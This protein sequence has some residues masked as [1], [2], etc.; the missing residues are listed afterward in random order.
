MK[1]RVLFLLFLS[2][3]FGK[4][5][6]VSLFDTNSTNGIWQ[7]VGVGG[8][9]IISNSSTTSSSDD[10]TAVNNPTIP[11]EDRTDS[12]SS[13]DTV[14]TGVYD[15]HGFSEDEVAISSI[16]DTNLSNDSF[17]KLNDSGTLVMY[18]YNPIAE[19]S[20]LYY[21]SKNS[22]SDNEF[23]TLKKGFGYWA[24]YDDTNL[25]F[26]SNSEKLSN[27]GF[28]F[29]NS[30]EMGIETYTAKIFEGWNL[31]SIPDK[32]T[33]ERGY[34]AT[35]DYD[36]NSE[37]NFSIA[38]KSSLD[39]RN[40]YIDSNS[41]DEA[42]QRL[43]SSLNDLDILVFESGIDGFEKSITFIGRNPFFIQND[44]NISYVEYPT[45]NSE[46]SNIVYSE[47]VNGL[48]VDFN[49]EILN[50]LP[51]VEIA[52]DGEEINISNIAPKQIATSDNSVFGVELALSDDNVT[53]LISD[54]ERD[55]TLYNRNYI[56]RYLNPDSSTIPTGF[57][58]IDNNT[59]IFQ[60]TSSRDDVNSSLTTIENSR[61]YEIIQG[62]GSIADLLYSSI[63]EN[64]KVSFSDSLN[65]TH[66]IST[67]QFPRTNNLKY[68]LSIVFDGYV[69]TQLLTLKDNKGVDEPEWLS[70]PIYQ[71]MTKWLKFISRYEP[72]YS[73]DKRKSY[74]VK[75][76]PVNPSTTQFAIDEKQ[77]T[78]NKKV[79]HQ[80][81]SDRRYINNVIHYNIQI[82]LKDV[83]KK[84]R[85]YLKIGDREIELTPELD[86]S[87]FTAQLDSEE[88]YQIGDISSIEKVQ[89]VIV[90]ENG[91]EKSID[92]DI[93][94]TQPDKPSGLL[95][96][97]DILKDS[98][99][100]IF[101][102]DL[103]NFN[104]VSNL[105]QNLCSDFGIQTL[106]VIRVDSNDTSTPLESLIMSNPL[107]K[108]YVSKYKGTSQLT[109]KPNGYSSIP[110]KYSDSCQLSDEV[111]QNEGVR[112]GASEHNISLFYK[113]S[114][115]ITTGEIKQFPNVMY[116]KVNSDILK[117]DFDSA[118]SY[119]NFYVVDENGVVYSGQFIPE[120]Y[121]S[122]STP[123]ILP[124]IE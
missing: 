53:L 97:D 6:S 84:M 19:N 28:I 69:P 13:T 52:I 58:S 37:Y 47:L 87:I 36:E 50:L 45:K 42:V 40:I 32:R 46:S 2:T 123:Y 109:T 110:V 122:S 102:E 5:Y 4:E 3:V 21:N 101:K 91:I 15:E 56:K 90:D 82:F 116:I 48:I 59:T 81:S 55:V 111:A 113:K 22:D 9:K 57:Y 1:K 79:F 92:L 17:D 100:K 108:S 77:S 11:T 105:K 74:W 14:S 78:I 96:F 8:L 76:A 88:L 75:F 104:E 124:I 86:G 106:Y 83:S 119:Q 112:I 39:I 120:V 62:Y 27:A 51:S 117:V 60:A 18:S 54:K 44:S 24:K 25:Q 41:T 65:G 23:T 103:E 95:S 94:F 35:L 70:I 118:Y 16:F 80:V 99:F 64:G 73:V 93:A 98:H 29:D 72:T 30:F 43:N 85:G 66:Y 68:F 63:V 115:N 67:Y 38:L 26:S 33:I 49:R 10:G 107:K 89:A 12:V 71:D 121:G 20:W 61:E 34:I 31:L 7:M 114:P